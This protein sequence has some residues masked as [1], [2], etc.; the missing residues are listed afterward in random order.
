MQSTQ[1]PQLIPQGTLDAV[2]LPGGEEAG[3]SHALHWP[4]ARC[5]LST[6]KGESPCGTGYLELQANG[7]FPRVWLSC[8]LS[9][10]GGNTP[11]RIVGQVPETRGAVTGLCLFGEVGPLMPGSVNKW[12]LIW[13]KDHLGWLFSQKEHWIHMDWEVLC[14]RDSAREIYTK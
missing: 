2:V 1:R 9:A 8:E 13:E 10:A 5:R 4:V 14:C 6:R 7:A 3:S 11:G 12:G